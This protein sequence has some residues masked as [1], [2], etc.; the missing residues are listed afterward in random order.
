MHNQ[1]RSWDCHVT[2]ESI[3]ADLSGVYQRVSRAPPD[4]VTGGDVIHIQPR[5]KAASKNKY[6]LWRFRI[7]GAPLSPLLYKQGDYWFAEIDHLNVYSE[8]FTKEEAISELETHIRH[9]RKYYNQASEQQLVGLARVLKD[10]F[11]RLTMSE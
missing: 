8:G 3:A 6:P 4:E 1:A 10:R 9:F 7:S 5:I 2:A 11:S